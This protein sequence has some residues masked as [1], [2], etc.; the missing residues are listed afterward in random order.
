MIGGIKRIII[1]DGVTRIG[2]YAFYCCTGLSNIDIPNGVTYI[3][4]FAFC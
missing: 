2:D 1:P 3:G 4:E